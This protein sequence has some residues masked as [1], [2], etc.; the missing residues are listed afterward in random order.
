MTASFGSGDQSQRRNTPPFT[1]CAVGATMPRQE[2][3]GLSPRVVDLMELTK[4]VY[5]VVKWSTL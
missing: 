3:T 2:G 5:D 4:A 1:V